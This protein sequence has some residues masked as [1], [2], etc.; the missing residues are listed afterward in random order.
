MINLIVT[1]GGHQIIFSKSN[2]IKSF[3]HFGQ[4]KSN[5]IILIFNFAQI[6]SNQITDIFKSNQI[7]LRAGVMLYQ[8]PIWLIPWNI[9]FIYKILQCLYLYMHNHHLINYDSMIYKICLWYQSY[10]IGQ[11]HIIKMPVSISCTRFIET[12]D[13]GIHLSFIMN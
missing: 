1:R 13:N 3:S 12:I 7:I 10:D 2:Q 5:Q 6:K 9:M 11:R 8:L 4:I